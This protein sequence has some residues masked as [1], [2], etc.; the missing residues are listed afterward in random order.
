MSPTVV[1][2]S[3]AGGEQVAHGA[4]GGPEGMDC[5]RHRMCGGRSLTV[6][7]S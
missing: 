7:V 5:W 6:G 3:A 2:S 1:V 4:A